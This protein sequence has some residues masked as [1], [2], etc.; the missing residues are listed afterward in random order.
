MGTKTDGEC[1]D[2]WFRATTILRRIEG[3]WLIVHDH[4]STPFYMDGSQRAALD[5]VPQD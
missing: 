1:V 5:L 2:L 3:R 4:T